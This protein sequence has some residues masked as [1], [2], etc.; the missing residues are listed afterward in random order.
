MRIAEGET[1]VDESMLPGESMPVDKRRGLRVRGHDQRHAIDPVHRDRRRARNPAGGRDPAGRRRARLQAP[2]AETGR[3]GGRGVRAGGG[4]DRGS[5]AP[6]LVVAGRCQSSG[7]GPRGV[8]A[9]DRLS[10]RAGTRDPDRVDGRDGP[11]RAPASLIRNADALEAAEKIDTLVFDKTGPDAWGAF[12]H[13]Y[14]S[15]NGAEPDAARRGDVENRSNIRLRVDSAPSG[16]GARGA[17]G[18]ERDPGAWGPGC[19]VPRR[20][21][22]AARLAGISRA[23]GD[24]IRRRRSEPVSRRW[25]DRGGCRTGSATSRLDRARRHVARIDAGSAGASR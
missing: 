4:R 13:R 25:Q 3:Q 20:E 22:G 12:G 21:H 24:R 15:C 17:D 9:G 14:L 5:D 1:S 2:G 7:S 18:G 19:V 10:V 6:F 11:L 8:G 16:G 23:S